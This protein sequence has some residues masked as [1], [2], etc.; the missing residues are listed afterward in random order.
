CA[1]PCWNVAT[2]TWR[3][4]PDCAWICDAAGECFSSENPFTCASVEPLTVRSGEGDADTSLTC[5]FGD[6]TAEPAR[7]IEHLDPGIAGDVATALGIDGHAVTS[8]VRSIK[9]C[10]QFHVAF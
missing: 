6:H 10:A 8:A 1:V 7:E 3:S 9:R 4:R 5:G 2:P